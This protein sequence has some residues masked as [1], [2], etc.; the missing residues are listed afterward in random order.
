MGLAWELPET[1]R[2]LGGRGETEGR[3]RQPQTG[4]GRWQVEAAVGSTNR[5]VLGGGCKS[6][7]LLL[8]APIL[9]V[10]GGALTGFRYKRR[11]NGPQENLTLS[12]LPRETVPA[13]GTLG[14]AW[15][16]RAKAVV[17]SPPSPGSSCRVNHKACSSHDLLQK[18]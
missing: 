14:R 7:C 11:P 16:P 12:N 4:T 17:G 8:P 1:G 13:P 18:S 5:L 3:G 15:V 2:N 6:R 9:E 10:H